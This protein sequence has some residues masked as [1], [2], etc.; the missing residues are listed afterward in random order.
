[1][2]RLRLCG[3]FAP[4]ARAEPGRRGSV[5]P[6]QSRLETGAIITVGGSALTQRR[7]SPLRGAPSCCVKRISSRT[8]R[9]PKVA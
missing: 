5:G 8:A 6:T 9:R 7:G 4:W 1:M 3:R 2:R